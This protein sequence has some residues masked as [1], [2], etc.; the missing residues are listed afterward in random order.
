MTLSTEGL[1][2]LGIILVM[3][4]ADVLYDGASMVRAA[5]AEDA[6][7][8]LSIWEPAGSVVATVLPAGLSDT[9]VNGLRHLGF[10]AHACLVLIFLNLIFQ[11]ELK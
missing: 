3:M 1:V 10:W 8:H 4:L 11:H 2:I 6:A 5:R 7:A 9:A